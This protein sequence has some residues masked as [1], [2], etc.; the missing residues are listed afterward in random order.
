MRRSLTIFEQSLGPQH[1][2]AALGLNNLAVL[3][4]GLGDSGEATQLHRRAK[5]IMTTSGDYRGGGERSG[6]ARAALG[7]ATWALRGSARAIYR[8]NARSAEGLEEGFEMAQWALQTG[9][10]DALTQMSVRFAKG[11]GPLAKLAQLVR[12]RQDLLARRQGEDKRLLVAVG[13]VDNTAVQVSRA[14]IAQLDDQ[15]A[16]NDRR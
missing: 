8:A 3:R 7:A 9:A 14:A 6:I 5:P 10:A 12:Q 13:S 1:P 16:V 2:N 4:A 11:A 15:L